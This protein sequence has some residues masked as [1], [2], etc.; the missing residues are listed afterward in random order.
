VRRG[1][2]ADAERLGDQVRADLGLGRTDKLPLDRLAANLGAELR[3]AGDL[4]DISRLE[5]IE[6]RQPGA[7]SACTFEIGQ[8]RIIVW[9]PLSSEARTNSDIAHELSHLLLK[10]AVKDVQTVASS[11]SSAAIQTK[12]RKQTGSPAAFYFPARSSLHEQA[13]APPPMTSPGS[14]KSARRWRTTGSGRPESCARF[15]H[16]D[17]PRPHQ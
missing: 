8:R 10:H 11:H 5:E 9:N 3:S 12:S 15:A 17:G 13:A 4:I 16:G 2:K 7:F 1:F 14:T 6:R